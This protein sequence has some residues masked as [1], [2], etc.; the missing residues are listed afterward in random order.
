MHDRELDILEAACRV[1]AREGAD[2]LRMSAVAQEAGVS[3]ALIHYYFATR[4]DLLV[5]AFEHADRQA[6]VAASRAIEGIPDALGRLEQL[7]TVYATA[8]RPFHEDWVLWVEMWRKAIFDHRMRPAVVESYA[9]WRGQISGLIEEA[10]AEGSVP[11]I[12]PDPACRRLIALVDGFGLQLI[13]GMIDRDHATQLI[14]SGIERE[15]ATS[16]AKEH[17]V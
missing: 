15:L 11:P 4:S 3:S 9:S 7:L 10:I 12:D 6:D 13:S 17:S 16:L 8:D 2:G 5:A 14:R 1:I